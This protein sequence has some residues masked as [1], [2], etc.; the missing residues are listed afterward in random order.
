[1]RYSE[2]TAA[3]RR[4][5][6]YLVDDAGDPVT[7]A[8]PT[9]SEIQASKSGAAW[10]NATGTWDE[11]G[12]G[13]YTYEATQAETETLSFL[14]L[15]V[16]ATG[17]RIYVYVADIGDRIAQDSAGPARR[18]PVYL[19]D[20]TGDPVAGLTLSGAEVQLSLAGAGWAEGDGDAEEIGLGAYY[21]ELTFA[22]LV[23]GPGVLRVADAAAQT[24]V[25]SWETR[26]VE[27]VVEDDAPEPIP[28]SI[29]YGSTIAEIDHV[30]AALARLPSM[31][32]G[33]L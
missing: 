19:V 22:E 3:L 27:A 15:R 21:Y 30:E 32:R 23:E 9:G 1:M 4:I 11:V 10:V 14:L 7:G 6:V 24:Y 33:S 16:A 18:V 8:A 17:A 20:D 25:Y 12:L 26:P 31:H 29:T 28:D 5:P 2:P 13:A